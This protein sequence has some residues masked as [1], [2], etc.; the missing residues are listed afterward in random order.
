MARTWVVES[1]VNPKGSDLAIVEVESYTRVVAKVGPCN[2]YGEACA[3]ARKMAAASAMYEAL[4]TLNSMIKPC[5]PC[6]GTG[7]H[8]TRKGDACHHC[9]GVG[10]VLFAPGEI[11]A[12]RALLAKAGPKPEEG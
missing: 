7:E 10:E 5:E 3:D 2:A 12:I 6:D 11:G 4:E 8:P 1:D 9:G